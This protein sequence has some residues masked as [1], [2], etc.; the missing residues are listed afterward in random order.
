MIATAIGV[1]EMSTH[2]CETIR[3]HIPEEG[4]FMVTTGRTSNL[5]CLKQSTTSVPVIAVRLSETI[6]IMQAKD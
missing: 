3:H 2:F 4:V 1:S 5:T 6:D